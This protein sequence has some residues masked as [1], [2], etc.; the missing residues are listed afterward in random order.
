M[1]KS[2]VGYLDNIEQET[3]GNENYRKVL[4]TGPNMQLVVM[5][6]ELNEE[7]GME[8]HAE[9]DQ[10]IRVEQGA[11]RVMLNDETLEL[12]EDEAV[13]IPAGTK[14]NVVN[15][16]DDLLKL[17]TIYT[18]PEHPEGTVQEAKPE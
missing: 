1:N 4:Y 9:H 13:I 15:I 16:G 2:Q 12:N 8:V 10:F 5:S 6:L 14:H 7:I 11:A 17:Y 18:P 3:L